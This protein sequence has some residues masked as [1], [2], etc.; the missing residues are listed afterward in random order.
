LKEFTLKHRG[1]KGKSNL[2]ERDTLEHYDSDRNW[3]L[4]G[5]LQD[6]HGIAKNEISAR[7][8]LPWVQVRL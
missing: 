2:E 6:M 5:I 3:V 8:D 7:K 1:A 4:R